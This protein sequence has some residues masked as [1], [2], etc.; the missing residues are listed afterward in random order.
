MTKLLV[1]GRMQ[2]PIPQESNF[3]LDD[4]SK[5]LENFGNVYYLAGLEGFAAILDID[6][7]EKLDEILFGS[8]F[9]RVGKI[10]ILPLAKN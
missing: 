3:K 7:L 6:S 10:E 9:S 1:V 5:K 2:K 8:E 4:L